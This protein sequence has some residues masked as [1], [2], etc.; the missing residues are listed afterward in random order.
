MNAQHR[1]TVICDNCG[2]D[3]PALLGIVNGESCV[4]IGY[5]EPCGFLTPG[6]SIPSEIA[7]A[8]PPGLDSVTDAAVWAT[9]APFSGA[10]I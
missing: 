7:V 5:C 9:V 10:A 6:H 3:I 4:F 1:L 2:S 8:S